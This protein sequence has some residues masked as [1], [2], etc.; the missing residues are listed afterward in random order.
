MIGYELP[1]MCAHRVNLKKERISFSRPSALHPHLVALNIPPVQSCIYIPTYIYFFYFEIVYSSIVRVFTTN[2][3][4]PYE[5]VYLRKILMPTSIH[6]Y[7]HIFVI[8]ILYIHTYSGYMREHNRHFGFLFWFSAVF[9]SVLFRSALFCS[10][11]PTTKNETL[12][13]TETIEFNHNTYT[14]HYVHIILIKK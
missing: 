1:K 4:I 9:R 7:L 6:A 13:S 11:C 12:Y 14:H 3:T 5:V 10:S 8:Y 2:T